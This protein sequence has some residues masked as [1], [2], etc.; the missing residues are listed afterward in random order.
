MTP[1]ARLI[2]VADAAGVSLRTASRVLNEDRR[3][4]AETRSRVLH[5]MRSLNFQPD[6]V[7]RSLRAGTDVSIGFVVESIADPFFSEVIDSVETA[8]GQFGRPVLVASTH[9][10][11]ARERE[12]VRRMLD[13]RVA[14][15]LLAPT[16]G[17][18]SW[19]RPD[20]TPLVLIDRA[21][22]G[23]SADLVDI[24]D[25]QAADDAVT[26]LIGYGH[27]RIAYIGDTSSIPTSAA[28]LEGYRAAHA[29][30][31]LPVADELVRDDRSTSREA[32]QAMG[33]LLGEVSLTAVF[34]ATT[35]A[36][37]GIV[38]VLHAR[39]RTDIA[40]V[41]IGDFAM[42]DALTPGI[43]VVAHSGAQ[44]GVAAANRLIERLADPGRAIEHVRLPATIIERGSGEIPA[45]TIKRG[46]GETPAPTI[47]RGPGET[48]AATIEHGPGESPETN[49][50]RGFGEIGP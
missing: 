32:A 35:R 9:R 13:R 5:A 14:G 18:H 8:M 12:V 38:P 21:A 49:I 11:D 3:V 39:A 44:I 25:R 29:R 37:L 31:G 42:A 10:D 30:H 19:L 28:R 45:P 22:P 36:S 6:A 50:D 16:G 7:A 15:L 43:T 41:G 27:R 46:P 20:R 4:A 48:P 33:E 47:K 40:F 26:H 34:S 24:D 1:A 2:D 23:V 17:D